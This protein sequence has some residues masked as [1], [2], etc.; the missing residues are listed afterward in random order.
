MTQRQPEIDTVNVSMGQSVQTHN[1]N[2]IKL[3]ILVEKLKFSCP[4]NSTLGIGVIRKDSCSRP[5]LW[6]TKKRENTD[7]KL[8]ECR[9]S[10]ELYVG[11]PNVIME[12]EIE[13]H[14]SS[15]CRVNHLEYGDSVTLN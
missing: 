15:Q 11:I 13:S 5:D 3:H 9:I 6:E 10:K 2:A 1:P 12:T 7:N 8:S 4:P 14:K